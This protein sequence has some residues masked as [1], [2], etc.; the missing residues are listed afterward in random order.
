MILLLTAE[1]WACS[2]C[3]DSHLRAALPGADVLLPVVLIYI[4][5][6]LLSR[7]LGG[8]PIALRRGLILTGLWLLGAAIGA[9]ALL[10][11]VLI[12]A[13]LCLSNLRRL[14]RA[15]RPW[16]RQASLDGAVSLWLLAGMVVAVLVGQRRA[17]D[18]DW[19]IVS[20][21][22]Q[23]GAPAI[24][25]RLLA[26]PDPTVVCP[27]IETVDVSTLAGSARLGWLSAAAAERGVCAAELTARLE[28]LDDADEAAVVVAL[29]RLAA[30]GDDLSGL[31]AH[32][33]GLEAGW[34]EEWAS[35][36]AVDRARAALQ[37]DC[38]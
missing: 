13:G 33:G 1:A 23:P 17:Q 28:G 7:P 24:Y 29:V 5:A 19:L 25:R 27:A 3:S 21:D 37:R 15:G 22:N 34:Y 38:P 31:C 14:R 35:Q 2:A 11:M 32:A 36:V 20:L 8:P 16:D 10:P 12:A 6:R 9:G 26:L 4:L 18:P 30:P